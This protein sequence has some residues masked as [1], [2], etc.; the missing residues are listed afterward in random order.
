MPYRNKTYVVFDGDEDMLSYRMMCAW[1]KNENINFNFH[2]AHDLNSARDDSLTESIKAQLRI[3]LANTKLMMVLIGAKTKSLRKF[4]PWEIEQAIDR[5]IPLI[6]INLNGSRERDDR[7][8]VTLANT[9]A[10]FVPFKQKIIEH[11]MDDWPASHATY[12]LQ[13][14]SSSYLYDDETYRYLG[15]G[16]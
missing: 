11:A 15:L 16:A 14:K 12:K 13:K 3:R 9:L 7:C 6:G 1:A 10:V 5:N 2:N 4:V 8:P